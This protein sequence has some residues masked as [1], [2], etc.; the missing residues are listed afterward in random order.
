M[1]VLGGGPL[2]E[3]I[4]VLKELFGRLSSH[5]EIVFYSF[6]KVHPD[7]SLPGVTIRRPPTLPLPGRILYL[8]I[9]ARLLLDHVRNSFSLIFAV[10]AYPT[11]KW[12]ISLGK[13]INR[14]V[15]VQLIALEAVSLPSIS[16]GNLS[17]P[18]LAEMTRKV[19][20]DAT[21]LVAVANYQKNVAMESLPTNRDIEVLPLRV[22]R[23]KFPYRERELSFPVQFIH[24]GYYSRLK[25]QDTM[26][27]AFA[28]VSRKIDC[29]LTVVGSGFDDPRVRAILN[30]K[31]IS[32]RVTI[33]GPVPQA[34]LPEVLHPAHIMLH[35]SVFETG[36]A[37]IQEAMSSGIAVCGT[38]VGILADLDDQFSISVPVGNS[39]MLAA[40]IIGL[41][42]DRS[43]FRQMTA[44]AYRWISSHDAEWASEKYRA[45]L[46]KL[47]DEN[48]NFV[49]SSKFS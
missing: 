4:P 17:V 40:R 48:P 22:D 12:A 37:V 14:P 2:G 24:V 23:S 29:H 32:H 33:A 20:R 30:E 9:G 36:C 11:G 19:C 18:W 1:D 5:F 46:E 6:S 35:T 42:N 3:G 10:S 8:M 16:R 38:R 43:R 34:S 28:S 26:F 7:K 31:E 25:D 21:G 47:I 44:A 27:E 45:Y 15:A 41:V 49:Q 13:L 39:E